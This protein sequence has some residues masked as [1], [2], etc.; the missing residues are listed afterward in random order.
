MSR[1]K[2]GR[3]YRKRQWGNRLPTSAH[4]PPSPAKTERP[5]FDDQ[6]FDIADAR[7]RNMQ[8]SK[9]TP[10]ALDTERTGLDISAAPASRTEAGVSSSHGRRV[11]HTIIPIS[12]APSFGKS[13]ETPQHMAPDGGG[14]SEPASSSE[15]PD[16]NSRP[17]D[18]KASS[19]NSGKDSGTQFRFTKEEQAAEKPF[20]ST[21]TVKAQ[22]KADKAHDKLDGARRKLPKKRVAKVRIETSESG[23]PKRRLVFEDEVK[24]RREHLKGPLASRPVKLAAN[25]AVA[26][27]H[28]KIYQVQDDNVGVEAAHKTEIAAEGA[29]RLFWRS[30]KT[31]PY[32]KVSKLEH[33]AEKADVKLHY[34]KTM[35]ANPQA[36]GNIFSRY[37]Q[38]RKIKRDYA[39]KARNARKAAKRAKK[40]A[41]AGKALGSFV[42]RHPMI[43]LMIL[44]FALLVLIIMSA[45]S[46]CSTLINGGISAVLA[47]SYTAPDPDIDGAE[48]AYLEWETDLQIE[49]ANAEQ[50]HPGFDEYRYS[51]DDVGHGPHE[52]MSYLTAKY[53]D[54]NLAAIQGDLRAIF[55]E[56]YKLEFVEEIEI[57][58]RTE[59]RYDPVSGE[60]YEVQ[61]PY[62]WRILN[63]I[64]TAQSFTDV[65]TP[66][67]NAEQAERYDLLM[68]IKGNRQYAGSPFN[69]NWINYVGDVY[70]WR[71]HPVT[72]EKDFHNGVDIVVAAGTEIIAAHDGTVIFAGNSA[73]YGLSVFLQGEKGVETRYAQ[74]SSVS[75]S[76]GQLVKMGDAI[77][78]VGGAGS[79]TGAH[80]HYEVLKNG[81]HRNPMYFAV[82]NDDGS[83]DIPPGNPGGADFPEY[84]GAPMDDARF[85]AIMEEAQKHLGKRYVF[86]SSGP[87]TFDC[88]G[89]VCYVL[90]HSGV[91]SV[92]RTNAQGLYNRCTPVSPENAQP[93][94]L[95]FF[96]GTY[97]TSNDCSHVGIYIGAGQMIHAGKPVKYSSLDQRYWEEH[98]YSYARLPS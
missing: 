43:A 93:G 57:R 28:K 2:N 53:N 15:Q 73:D 87:D 3:G 64:M 82:T 49:I 75:V 77:A 42:K 40:A 32:R 23:K 55:D 72:G 29:A 61:V 45:A 90:N 24:S 80:L 59:T 52:L 96:S 27:A 71:V 38:K 83:S 97:N 13:K 48:L 88:S 50:T 84:P 35:D 16:G 98:F 18:G 20:Q 63:V 30:H 7:R 26:Y 1:M 8:R 68:E 86:G 14:E 44:A 78:Q 22:K 92:G 46:S 25:A 66:K 85:A 6:D 54:F 79:I 69:F 60:S 70:G 34:R 31:A 62:E 12:A 76:Q 33:R 4:H 94:D 19:D 91:A 89:F 58:Y 47:T 11:P 9:Y 37:A 67:L 65:I 21:K 95:I 39:K 17:A 74:C 41:S 10:S 56:Q 51:V 5:I 36:S 81:Q